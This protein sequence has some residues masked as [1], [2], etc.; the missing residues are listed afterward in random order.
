M[1]LS[2][3]KS[4][5]K[6]WLQVRENVSNIIEDL[7]ESIYNEELFSHEENRSF[8]SN[9]ITL[10]ADSI[11]N[12]G[13]FICEECGEEEV[14]GY[15]DV[16]YG[17]FAGC[18]NCETMYE[19]IEDSHPELSGNPTETYLGEVISDTLESQNRWK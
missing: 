13:V 14:F 18:H 5:L 19:I 4:L 16:D 11:Y 1:E 12:I 15:T 8:T 6:H 7:E 10:V 9:E 17:K 3:Q 2:K